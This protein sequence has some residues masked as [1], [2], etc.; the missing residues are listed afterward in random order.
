[1]LTF[2]LTLML[3]VSAITS[4][5]TRDAVCA[6]CGAAFTQHKVAPRFTALAREHGPALDRV[7]PDGW[8]PLDCPRCERRNLA[9][10]RTAQ[11]VLR[12]T[13]KSAL[14]D[15]QYY[16]DERAGMADA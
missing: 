15:G 7:V 5:E 8:V 2:L 12:W 16:A 13:E 6:A 9:G 14:T 4:P 1:M 3:T 10:G 11:E